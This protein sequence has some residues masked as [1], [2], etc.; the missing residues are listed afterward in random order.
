MTDLTP[1]TAL[2]ATAARNETIGAYLIEENTELGLASVAIPAETI[3]PVLFGLTLPKPGHLTLEIDGKFAIWT[4][5]NQWLFATDGDAHQD[6]AALVKSKIAMAYITEQ[7][8]AWVAFKVSSQTSGQINTLLERLVN[9]P[10]TA[11]D[12]G[13]ATRTNI[14]HMSVFVLRPTSTQVTFLGPRTQAGSLWHVL[15]TT[16]RQQRANSGALS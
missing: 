16:L 3:P 2:G 1:R 8:D 11:T 5:P 6:C 7:T 13:K 4:A 9:L 15:E 10:E 12:T 14:H